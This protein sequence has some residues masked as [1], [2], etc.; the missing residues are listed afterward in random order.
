MTAGPICVCQYHTIKDSVKHQESSSNGLRVLDLPLL[1]RREPGTSL[2]RH[3]YRDCRVR[4][5]PN[6]GRIDCTP[7]SSSYRNLSF[8]NIVQPK[9]NS[10]LS[11][12]V[13]SEKVP[14]KGPSVLGPGYARPGRLTVRLN[15]F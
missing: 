13:I 14:G 1:P 10:F 7:T 12:A 6:L 5:N 4:Q 8:S 9:S 15:L 11:S 3:G 2:G